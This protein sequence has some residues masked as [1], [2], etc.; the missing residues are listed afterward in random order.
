MDRAALRQL[1]LERLQATLNRV[2]P[3]TIGAS[4]AASVVWSR[5]TS[6]SGTVNIP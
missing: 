5:M 6:R 2:Y 3:R 1:Q 4:F